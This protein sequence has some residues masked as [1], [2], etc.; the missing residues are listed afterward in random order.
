MRSPSVN[1]DVP[2]ARRPLQTLGAIMSTAEFMAQ[3]RM[4]RTLHLLWWAA[5]PITAF[6]FVL[7]F[8]PLPRGPFTFDPAPV[9]GL[10]AWFG[11]WLW[12]GHRLTSLR[13]PYCAKRAFGLR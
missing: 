8:G 12:L 7:L 5:V 3:V 13:C 10:V 11:V 2:A 4:R 9:F 6:P 1:P